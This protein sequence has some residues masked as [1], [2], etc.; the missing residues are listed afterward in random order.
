VIS[1][2]HKAM[3]FICVA[4]SGKVRLWATATWSFT[5]K[6]GLQWNRGYLKFIA[7]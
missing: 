5:R 7:F 2:Y 6:Q 3:F 1:C 4:Y